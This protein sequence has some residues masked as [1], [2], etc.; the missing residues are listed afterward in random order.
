[1]YGIE[2]NMLYFKKKKRYVFIIIHIYF[3]FLQVS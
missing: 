1:M 3:L 2:Y